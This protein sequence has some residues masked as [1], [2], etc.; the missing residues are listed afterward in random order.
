LWSCIRCTWK[1]AS[2]QSTCEMCF[3]ERDV[4]DLTDDTSYV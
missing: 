4:V 1:N 3:S 2:C